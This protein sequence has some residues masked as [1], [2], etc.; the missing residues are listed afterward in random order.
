MPMASRSSEEIVYKQ[1][2]FSPNKCERRRNA[3][4]KVD[5]RVVFPKREL[6]SKCFT[7]MESRSEWK[8]VNF[9]PAEIRVVGGREEA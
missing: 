7:T 4:T 3:Q 1:N 9:F 8:R 5:R 2:D 6:M